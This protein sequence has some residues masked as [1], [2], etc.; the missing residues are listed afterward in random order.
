VS[1]LAD[2]LR[3]TAAECQRMAHLVEGELCDE[4]DDGDVAVMQAAWIAWEGKWRGPYDNRDGFRAELRA[5]IARGWR[6]G[7]P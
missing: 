2:R 4:I 6:K 3:A 1:D 7:K 5:L